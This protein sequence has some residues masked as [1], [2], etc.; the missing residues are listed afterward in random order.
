MEKSVL[1]Q[2]NPYSPPSGVPSGSSCPS[3]T[4][5]TTRTAGACA[6][7]SASSD[8]D[9]FKRRARTMFSRKRRWIYCRSKKFP[10]LSGLS[11]GKRRIVKQIQTLKPSYSATFF[12]LS[13]SPP[14][15]CRE[16]RRRRRRHCFFTVFSNIFSFH[17][18]LGRWV[19]GCFGG[20]FFALSVSMGWACW[21][22]SVGNFLFFWMS[23]LFPLL[24]LPGE[25]G[26]ELWDP[27]PGSCHIKKTI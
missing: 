27:E 11:S 4:T 3:R 19:L 10:I 23:A 17:H 24:H 6:A 22:C 8:C 7:K 13:C 18:W 16:K 2:Q 9:F 21:A 5:R 26:D 20:L 15:E 14:R 25:I 12:Y 1:C